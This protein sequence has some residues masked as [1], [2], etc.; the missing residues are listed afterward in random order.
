MR[1][2]NEN[3]LDILLKPLYDGSVSIVFFNK[4]DKVTKNASFAL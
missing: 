1:V 4:D 2:S 3:N